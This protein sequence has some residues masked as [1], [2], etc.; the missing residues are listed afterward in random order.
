MV[1]TANDR[2][3]P[4]I[5]QL[6]FFVENRL[7]ALRDITRRL[8]KNEVKMQAISILEAA[9]HAVIRLVVDKVYTARQ[10]L[11]DGGYKV[12]ENELLGVALPSG[13]AGLHPV[14]SSLLMGEID[15]KYV[16][17]LIERVDGHPV[18]VLRVENVDW[19][20]HVLTQAGLAL[21]NHDEL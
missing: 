11:E 10:A 12:Y 19:A 21:V 4:R 3:S 15:I 8:E 13:S 18:L 1:E 17:S 2:T 14:L 6:S 20:S 9:D 7:G 5:Q 16:Y